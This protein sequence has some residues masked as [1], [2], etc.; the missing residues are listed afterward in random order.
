VIGGGSAM[1][2][3]RMAIA[4]VLIVVGTGLA[5]GRVPGA[6]AVGAWTPTA[7]PPARAGGD[8][9]DL[10]AL[11]DG[12]ILLT[13][14]GIFP[15]GLREVAALYDPADASWRTIPAPEVSLAFDAPVVLRDGQV[16][17]SG[18]ASDAISLPADAFLAGGA[19]RY[20]PATNRWTV[21]APLRR[22]ASGHTALLLADGR[23]F[24]PAGS[25]GSPSQLY[26]PAR[27]LWAFDAPSPT[28]DGVAV[29]LGDGRILLVGQGSAAL[30]TVGPAERACFPATGKCIV[31]PF[32]DYWRA[33]GGL[34]ING[35]PLGDEQIEILEDGQAYTVQYFERSRLEH[36]PE[37]GDPQYRILLGQF[38]RRMLGV[39][40]G[41]YVSYAGYRQAIAPAAPLAAARYF[42]E[43]GHNLGG[44]FRAYWE[45]NGGL[46]QF[47]LPLTEERFDGLGTTPGVSCCQTQYFERA[48]FE[49]HPENAGTPYEV[50]LGQF[51]RQILAD[52]ANLGGDLGRLYATEA[53]V[54]DRLG[55]PR[56]PQ[57]AV[58]GA[59]QPFEHGLMIWRGDTKRIFVLIGSPD[60]GELAVSTQ[61]YNTDVT[62]ADT[63]AQGQDPGGGAA[64]VAGRFLPKRGFGK[65]WHEQDFRNALGYATTADEQGFAM[66]IQQFAAGWLLTT[67]GPGGRSTYAIYLQATGSHNANRI[68]SYERVAAR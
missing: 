40:Y 55:A 15:Q 38:G 41:E 27:D 47:G 65:L 54:R 66:T 51:G 53:R 62:W 68:G 61:G 16:L 8:P 49:Y 57:V 9:G 30:Y 25:T 26:D 60:T 4:T 5:P 22:A 3:W 28:Y 42:P 17:V 59:A 64:P 18:G 52:N 32:L 36:H 34:A 67:E 50:L 46:A 6:A 19:Q 63:W 13:R 31:G 1:R 10:T 35:Y 33:H 20:D 24:I 39:A 48:R 23:A 29:A 14:L 58:P 45:A 2:W 11:P 21:V 56:G 44:R 37:I 7:V 43:T 12:R